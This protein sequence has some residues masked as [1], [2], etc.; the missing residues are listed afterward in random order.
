M[1]PKPEEA[2]SEAE[3]SYIMIDTFSF[4]SFVD[5]IRVYISSFC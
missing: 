1:L 5:L 3:F 2:E 4:I